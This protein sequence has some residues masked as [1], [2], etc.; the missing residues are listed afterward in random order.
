MLLLL[1]AA[2]IPPLM[3]TQS[4]SSYLAALPALFV[5]AFM[6][7]RRRFVV[8]LMIIGLIVSPLFLPSAV[9]ERIAYTFSQRYHQEQIQIGGIRLDTSTSARLS[10]WIE[11]LKDWTKHPFIGYGVTGYAFMD[12]QFV[13]VL[14]ETGIMGLAAF[15]YLLYGLFRLIRRTWSQVTAPLHQGLLRGFLAG[16]VA[17]LFHSIG[18]NTFIIVRIMEP[19]WFVVGIVAILPAIEAA[20]GKA[21]GK[22]KALP[23]GMLDSWRQKRRPAVSAP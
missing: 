6:S 14:I 4:R 23:G 12:A 18:A 22:N 16:Y 5:L 3:A 17:I 1:I 7:E 9:K 15:G 19:F 20:R 10:S 21:S 2:V 11:G 8:P 13:R